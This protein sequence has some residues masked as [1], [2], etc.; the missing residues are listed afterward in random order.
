MRRVLAITRAD[1]TARLLVF[2][3]WA[4]VLELLAHAL[5]VWLLGWLVLEIASDWRNAWPFKAKGAVCTARKHGGV[6]RQQHACN[7]R[8]RCYVPLHAMPTS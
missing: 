8:H 2:S 6:V 3:Q 1:A 5:Q 4:D 7:I